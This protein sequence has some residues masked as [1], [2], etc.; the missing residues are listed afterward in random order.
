V[1][2]GMTKEQRKKKGTNQGKVVTTRENG[3]RVQNG[4]CSRPERRQKA[5]RDIRA[6]PTE[7]HED[8]QAVFAAEVI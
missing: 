6:K 2:E 4:C 8:L 7:A 3:K 5:Q 1:K